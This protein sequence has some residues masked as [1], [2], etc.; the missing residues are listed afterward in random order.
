MKLY[1]KSGDK[2][3]TSLIGGKRVP[4]YD[5]RVE[6][7]GTIDE[8][9]SFVG[10]TLQYVQGEKLS[11]VK[12]ELEEIQQFLFD[13][14]TDLAN[15]SE[16]MPFRIDAQNVQW[17]ET[18]IDWYS[19]KNTPI[20]R[21][22]LPGGSQLASW[23]HVDRTI[24]RRVEREIVA[25]SEKEEINVECLK[26]MNRLSDYFFAV[27]RYCNQQEQVDDTFYERSDKVFHND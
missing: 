27:A 7:Y 16:E 3:K 14:G 24:A 13:V 25:L 10:V 6:C 2:G 1:T 22:I 11:K 21:F 8:L 17:L 18:C 5:T 20:E 9:N 26:W 19:A 12:A 15:V 4:K 23:L